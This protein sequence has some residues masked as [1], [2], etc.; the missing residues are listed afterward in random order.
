[1]VVI[2]VISD[3]FNQIPKVKFQAH[4]GDFAQCTIVEN[5][6]ILG[7]GLHL[8]EPLRERGERGGER[9]GREGGGGG[10]E[11]ERG[12]GVRDRILELTGR[13]KLHPYI[14][15]FMIHINKTR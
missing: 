9:G 1:V 10:R 7:H 15:H 11:G 5:S 8:W 4:I 3:S 14:R 12:E 2:Y 13:L 6:G